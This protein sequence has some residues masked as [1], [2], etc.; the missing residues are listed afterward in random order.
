MFT[1]TVDDVPL[2]AKVM[3]TATWEEYRA[4]ELGTVEILSAGNHQVLI[5]ANTIVHAAAMNLHKLVLKPEP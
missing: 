3:A 1:I 5:Q 2:T 4:F